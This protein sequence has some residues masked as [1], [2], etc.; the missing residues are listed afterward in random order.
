MAK[1]QEHKVNPLV[2]RNGLIFMI[3]LSVVLIITN[4]TSDRYISTVMSQTYE[5]VPRGI[6]SNRSANSAS[7][8]FV[9]AAYQ[10]CQTNLTLANLEIEECRKMVME[11]RQY[12]EEFL[13]SRLQ[14]SNYII[15]SYFRFRQGGLQ[16]YGGESLGIFN[17]LSFGGNQDEGLAYFILL[18]YLASF[19]YFGWN[20]L[21]LFVLN[22]HN[23]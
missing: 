12:I 16:P 9:G 14:R 18:L 7:G 13:N 6:P 20:A 3:F 2:I 4:P 23:S 22:R 19:R 11:K 15:L 5:E 1:N 17:S 8:A 21:N 10:T